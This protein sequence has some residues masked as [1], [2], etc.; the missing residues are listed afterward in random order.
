MDEARRKIKELPDGTLLCVNDRV[1]FRVFL[2]CSLKYEVLRIK[3][4]SLDEEQAK[5]NSHDGSLLSVN[6]RVGVLSFVKLFTKIRDIRIS[7]V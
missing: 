5:R 1:G 7:E 6:D 2:S 3:R 4:V